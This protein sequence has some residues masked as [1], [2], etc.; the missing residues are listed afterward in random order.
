[1]IVE[2]V[3]SLLRT[4][5]AERAK[6]FNNPFRAS[7]MGRCVREGCFDLLGLPGKPLQPRRMLTLRNGAII[8]DELLTP[9]LKKALGWRFVDEH[10]WGR[11]NFVEIDGVKIGYHID[12]AFQHEAM[13]MEPVGGVWISTGRIIHSI[14][15]VEIKSMS[16]FAFDKAKKGEIDHEY[17]CQAWVY[18]KATDFNPVVFLAYRKETSAMVEIVFDRHAN[19]KVVTQKLTGDPVALAKEDP[20]LLTEIKSPFDE[21]V[22][23]Y[24]RG[25]IRYLKQIRGM[26]DGGVDINLLT[27]VVRLEVPGANAVEDEVEKVQGQGKAAAR[28]DELHAKSSDV[29]QNGSWYSIKTGRRVLKFPCSYCAHMERCFPEATMELKGDKP[30]WVPRRRRRRRLRDS[31][32]NRCL[33][34]QLLG[35]VISIVGTKAD[36]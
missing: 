13:E 8:H 16:D 14:G 18:F 9:L 1:M 23:D 12:G 2:H 36:K 27:D 10:G 19:E 28:A 25:R 31:S 3:E 5:A 33:V 21:S 15:V 6:R 22:Q 24:V 30:I 29:T 32:P 17:L 26:Q 7:S 4:E 34:R 11:D 35:L 20:I